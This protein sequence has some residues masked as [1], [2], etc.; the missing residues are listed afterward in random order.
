MMP[1]TR[2]R[3]GKSLMFS[4]NGQPKDCL[5]AN[6]LI[7]QETASSVESNHYEPLPIGRWLLECHVSCPRCHHYHRA[8]ELKIDI[9]GDKSRVS[10]VVCES[11]KEPWAAFGNRNSTQLSLLSV[12]TVVPDPVER[13]VHR[14]LVEI[15]RPA[16][17]MATSILANDSGAFCNAVRSSAVLEMNAAASRSSSAKHSGSQRRYSLRATSAISRVARG[18]G[19]STRH[20]PLANLRQRLASRLSTLHRS[21]TAKSPVKLQIPNVLPVSVEASL[22]PSTTR[23]HA[24]ARDR[25]HIQ[26]HRAHPT[27]GDATAMPTLSS[28]AEAFIEEIKDDINEFMSQEDRIKWARKKFTDFRMRR[29]RANIQQESYVI[30]TASLASLEALSQSP[31]SQLSRH[32]SIDVL[33]GSHRGEFDGLYGAD[34]VPDIQRDSI[35][36]R[37]S[38]VTT[39]VGDEYTRTRAAWQ[40]LRP[41]ERRDSG[42]SRPLS[43]QSVSR[44][45]H[46]HQGRAEA[47]HSQDFAIDAAAA[48]NISN[49]RARNSHRWSGGSAPRIS[50]EALRSQIPLPGTLYEEQ[51]RND[52][53]QSN[54]IPT[55]QP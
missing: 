31:A 3:L 48:R 16:T 17:A 43:I 29:T 15:I 32:H 11:C 12:V 4:Q 49:T 44:S 14:A 54:T 26:S 6:R 30:D 18:G 27:N 24:E 8:S 21:G 35:S 5:S 52:G 55:P 42:S 22:Q 7:R 36:E 1:G 20:F 13:E 53:D 37:S 39:M 50:G 28:E 51:G 23:G 25:A 45:Q 47:R 46:I 33:I 41:Q 2:S 38:E 40:G 34:L 10:P 19:P 9:C